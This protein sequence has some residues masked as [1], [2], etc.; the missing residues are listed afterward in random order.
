MNGSGI[1][2]TNKEEANNKASNITIESLSSLVGFPVDYLKKELL[3]EGDEISL[4][5]LRTRMLSF[6]DTNFIH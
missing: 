4:K 2:L 3:L 5:D 6:L 1:E